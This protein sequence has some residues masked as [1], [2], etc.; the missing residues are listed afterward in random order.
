MLAS[1]QLF[2]FHNEVPWYLLPHE[3]SYQATPVWFHVVFGTYCQIFTGF[4]HSMCD[5]EQTPH[6]IEQFRVL[7]LWVSDGENITNSRKKSYPPDA[8]EVLLCSRSL[9]L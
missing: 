5:M 9:S 3:R 8:T 4:Q 2:S 6:W 7:L 1:S